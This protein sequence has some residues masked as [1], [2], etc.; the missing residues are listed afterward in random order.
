MNPVQAAVEEGTGVR[1]RILRAA[2]AEFARG[3]YH[4]TS[5]RAIAQRSGSNKPMI[6]YHFHGKEGLYLAAVRL[7]MEEMAA[8]LAAAVAGETDALRRLR[9]FAEVYLTD[10]VVERPL[11]GVTLRELEGLPPA[12]YH[13]IV[14]DYLRLIVPLLRQIL[15][16]GVERGAFRPLDAD[17]CASGIIALLHGYLRGRRPTPERAAHAVTQ[18]LDYYAVGLLSRRSLA[19]HLHAMDD[20]PAS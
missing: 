12:L 20:S 18:I 9:R 4:L 10:F 15:A 1:E 6:Y 7:L 19:A 5:L 13:A 2:I 17:E 14:E 3:G 11:L 8:R 16:E